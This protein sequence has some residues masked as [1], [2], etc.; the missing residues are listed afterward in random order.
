[1][2]GKTT[3]HRVRVVELEA[4]REIAALGYDARPIMPLVR[5]AAIENPGFDARDIV[6]VL[7]AENPAAFKPR[8]VETRP[9]ERSL[10]DMSEAEKTAFVASRGLDA[11]RELVV[12]DSERRRAELQRQ[13]RGY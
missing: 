1:M 7:K 8:T 9:A 4:E 13:Y 12:R 5:E 6:A 3:D 11:F 10:S 2:S